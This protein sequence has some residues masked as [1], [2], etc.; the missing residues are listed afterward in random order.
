MSSLEGKVAL[1][2]GSGR[3]L[4]R[5]CARIFARRGAK[6]VVV[7]IN[8]ETGPE[9]VRLI[10]EAGGE[11]I[12]S[13]SDISTSDGVKAMVRAAVDTWGGL[14]CAINNALRPMAYKPLADISE[15]EWHAGLAVNLTGVF[16]CMKY[17][18]QAMLERGGGS[19]VNIGSGNEFGCAQGLS[20]YFGAKHGIYGLTKVAALEYAKRGIRVNALG[21]GP[22]VA[23]P[24]EKTH[25]GDP[26]QEAFLLSKAPYGRL[27]RYEEV[28]EAA[29]WLCTSEAGMV[30]GHTLVADGGAM[31]T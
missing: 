24:T 20:W 26:Q 8:Q 31:L 29:V 30:L 13:P 25:R 23:D 6:V 18:I 15:E 4:G 27:A 1:V 16:M 2:T 22:M 9:T 7:D 5:E 10:K 17:E 19:I 28:A 11:A 12:F 3:G 21:P 14:D